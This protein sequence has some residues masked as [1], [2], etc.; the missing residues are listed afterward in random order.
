MYSN[1]YLKNEEISFTS[2]VENKKRYLFLKRVLDIV[3]ALIALV[4][5]FPIIAFT[6]ILI[7]LESKGPAFFT[8]ERMGLNGKKFYIYKLRSMRVDAEKDG[9]QW[10]SKNDSRV[11]RVGK[12]IRKTRIDELP[13]LINVLKGDMSIFGPRPERPV[14][15][16][17][18]SREIPGFEKRL[19]V[20]PGLSGW[21]QVNGGYDISPKEKLE[22]D[23]FYIQNMNMKLDFLIFVKTIKVLITGDGAR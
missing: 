20:K 19:L 10:A 13:Q 1:K 12:F 21:A 15:V 5:A 2:I 14:F 16:E 22:Y 4:V 8:Q 17:Q 3:I 7:K 9:P 18:F 23:L 6:S 11:T